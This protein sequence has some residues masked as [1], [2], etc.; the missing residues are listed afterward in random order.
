MY[1]DTREN[2]PLQWLAFGSRPGRSR[3]YHFEQRLDEV[4]DDLNRQGLA[5]GIEL[6]VTTATR[7]ALDGSLMAANTSR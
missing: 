2:Q 7:A 6:Q 5:L 1:R 3:F 4:V